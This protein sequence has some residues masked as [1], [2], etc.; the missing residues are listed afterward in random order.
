MI[1]EARQ[2]T[3]PTRLQDSPGHQP[4]LIR[5]ND[6]ACPDTHAATTMH[7]YD[8][9]GNLTASKDPL[10]RATRFEYDAENR[11][12]RMVHR[13]DTAKTFA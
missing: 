8:L 13:D 7:T 9:A 10:G 11:R 4:A 2:D 6:S 12:V 5:L 3:N 1:R